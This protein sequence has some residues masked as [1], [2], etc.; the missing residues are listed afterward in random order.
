MEE[1]VAIMGPIG[2]WANLPFLNSYSGMLD[3]P[4]SGNTQFAGHEGLDTLKGKSAYTIGE[5]GNLGFVFQ[6]F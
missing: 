3:N 2:L 1:F 4:T 6:S 5:K